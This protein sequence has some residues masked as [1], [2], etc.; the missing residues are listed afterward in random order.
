MKNSLINE[1]E[2]V[3]FTFFFVNASQQN[4]AFSPSLAN[5]TGK[6][7]VIHQSNPV[8]NLGFESRSQVA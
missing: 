5:F 3:I 1:D 8:A 7:K 4:N 2:N 6:E